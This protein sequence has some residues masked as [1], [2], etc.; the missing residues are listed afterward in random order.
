[1]NV[2][3]HNNENIDSICPVPLK[4][5]P[6]RE[7]WHLKQRR[8]FRWAILERGKYVTKLVAVWISALLLVLFILALRSP[9]SDLSDEDFWLGALV[10]ELVVLLFL[11]RL[12]SAW[13]HIYSRLIGR[14]IDYQLMATRKTKLWRKSELVLAQDLLVARFQVRPILQRLDRSMVLLTII[15]SFN[16]LILFVTTNY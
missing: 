7:Y 1:M 13:H 14:E 5:Q 10:A 4:Q 11:I 2:V 15:M 8:F 9:T 3:Q 16:F 12:Y 6:I